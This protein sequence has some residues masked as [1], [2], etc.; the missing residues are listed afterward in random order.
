[1]KTYATS[2]LIWSLWLFTACQSK[3]SETY[4]SQYSGRSLLW[5]LT[6]LSDCD[7]QS[8]SLLPTAFQFKNDGTVIV[9]NAQHSYT[10]HWLLQHDK[11][12]DDLPAAD[13]AL[14]LDFNT[15]DPISQLN[16]N[17]IITSQ[18]LDSISLLK[19]EPLGKKQ[20]LLSAFP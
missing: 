12:T 4:F 17:W 9:A 11:G 10:G 6:P 16:G 18:S 8:M 15:A 13:Q 3:S 7:D 19:S 20:L 5:K 14:Q 2:F 1:M